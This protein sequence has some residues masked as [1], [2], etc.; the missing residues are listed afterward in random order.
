MCTIMAKLYGC[1][2]T[3]WCTKPEIF[4]LGLHDTVDDHKTEFQTYW[5]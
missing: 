4:N 3:M 5:P 2:K 1:D